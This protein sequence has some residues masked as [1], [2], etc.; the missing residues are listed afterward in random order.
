MISVDKNV[1]DDATLD[2]KVVDPKNIVSGAPLS[3]DSN[4]ELIL[5]VDETKK[6]YGLAMFDYNPYRDQVRDTV[7]G[8]YGSGKGAVLNMGKATIGQTVYHDPDGT[9]HALCPYDTTDTF[10]VLS[11]IGIED[12]TGKIIVTAGTLISTIGYVVTPPA[13][14][15]AG[16]PMK[17]MVFPSSNMATS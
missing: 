7:G 5:A 10:S 4:N 12:T 11:P 17:V 9:P 6:V 14:A 2:V 16:D 15:T 3:I 8:L 1:L 13:D